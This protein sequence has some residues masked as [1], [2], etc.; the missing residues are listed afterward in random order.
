MTDDQLLPPLAPPPESAW[1]PENLEGLAAARRKYPWWLKW[2]AA[3]AALALI[4]G[5]AGTV[6][7]VPY[8]TLSPGGTLALERRVSVAG[9]K[10]ESDRGVVMLLFV[11]LRSHIDL[12]QWLQAK[13]DP[14]IDLVKQINE[15]G[16]HSQ[17]DADRQDVCD[18]TQS[19]IS[20]RVAALTALGYR[21]PVI[22][23]LDVINLPESYDE[24]GPDGKTVTRD[25]PAA[26]VLQ[27]C[28]EIVAADG[29]VL[30]QPNDLSKYVKAHRAGTAI[31]LRIVRAGH[32]QTVSVPVVAALN[33]HLI[34]VDLGL[35]Y[36]IP[37]R[38]NIDT[39]D[40]GG[41]SAGLAMALA[42]VN[43]LTPGDLT[44]GKRVAVTGTIDAAGRVGEIGGLPQKAVAA[45]A[46]HAQIFIV[47]KCVTAAT[48]AA[49]QKDLDTAQKR[50]GKSV[51]LRP[52]STLTE[53]LKVLRA[54][55]GAEV[56]LQSPPKN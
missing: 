27:P 53:A 8:D 22:S 25:F 6:I 31:A 28:D 23:G 7:R 15:T 35:R 52:V 49:C 37:L 14:D 5:V 38:I 11:R 9:V 41:P 32:T 2:V 50:V 13:I 26:K 42:I 54:A 36:K 4:I 56:E 12:W 19:Q 34:G 44:G 46:S 33:T 39:S 1:P 48:K 51:E 29:H 40:I 30:K 43:A 16:G 24:T 18:M 21:V 3:M 10:P 45:R 20:A 55:G 17:R 47:P